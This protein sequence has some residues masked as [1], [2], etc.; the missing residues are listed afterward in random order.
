MD[1]VS[2]Q[3]AQIFELKNIKSIFFVSNNSL[4]SQLLLQHICQ[5]FDAECRI[6]LPADLPTDLESCDLV[7]LN[8]AD[9]P[10]PQLK[11]LLSATLANSS[12]APVVI[13]NTDRVHPAYEIIEWPN[14]KGLFHSDDSS[15]A[16]LKGIQTIDMGGLWL[17]R[18]YAEHLA[19]M[20]KPPC[21]SSGNGVP[22]THREQQ[23]M[24]LL[25]NGLSNQDMAN[26]LFISPHTIKTHI[27][28]LYKK[29]GAKNRVQALQW[30]QSAKHLHH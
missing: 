22:L 19:K 20:R 5:S 2:L 4:S 12:E 23:I 13:V 18:K 14:I 26:E 30:G 15:A 6:A 21:I 24:G 29:I 7:L 1:S 8:H 16:L 3:T 10:D 11:K 28:K 17:P 9:L 25:L 27:Y